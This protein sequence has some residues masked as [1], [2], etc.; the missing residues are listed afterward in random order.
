MS[1]GRDKY[2]TADPKSPYRATSPKVPNK[3]SRAWALQ[4][5]TP[6]QANKKNSKAS[7]PLSAS[8]KVVPNSRDKNDKKISGVSNEESLETPPQLVPLELKAN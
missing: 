8:S 3:N 7:S 2:N 6:S 4:S 1:K 5:S